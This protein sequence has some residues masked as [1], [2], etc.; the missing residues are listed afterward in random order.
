M[1]TKS[2]VRGHFCGF[3]HNEK[4]FLASIH[5]EQFSRL[6][7]CDLGGA[8]SRIHWFNFE[9]NVDYEASPAENTVQES[10]ADARLKAAKARF[11][12]NRKARREVKEVEKVRR[13]FNGDMWA[14]EP[15][16]FLGSEEKG[17]LALQK[18]FVP[19]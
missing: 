13:T 3:A 7:W 10:I 2:C 18:D 4:V 17:D 11:L 5:C 6:G 19:F 15:E 16:E 12:Q 1:M 8:C 9:S 14:K